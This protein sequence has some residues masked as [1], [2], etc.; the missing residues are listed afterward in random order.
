[1]FG[2]AA[3]FITPISFLTSAV[4]GARLLMEKAAL[5]LGLTLGP[6]LALNKIEFDLL[7]TGVIGGTVAYGIHRVQRMRSAAS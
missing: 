1:V 4:R 6:L 5:I 7:W 3:M 2:A